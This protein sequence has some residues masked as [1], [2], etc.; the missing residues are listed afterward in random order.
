MFSLN[1]NKI[2]IKIRVKDEGL[3]PEYATEG[4][5][6]VDLRAYEDGYIDIN[7]SKL[8]KTGIF[9]EIPEG[10][11]AQVRPR[12]GLALKYRVTVLNSP[13]TIDIISKTDRGE[14]GVIL[15]NLGK[16]RFFYKKGDRIAQM[17]FSPIV[18]GIFN[19]VDIISKTDRGD[20]GFGH[21]GL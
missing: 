5:S 8:V 13:G 11:E 2:E 21:T 12:S 9:L 17:V 1:K 14:I 15:I 18:K 4:S 6:G 7:E 16:E 3:I 20:G 10:F 19:K